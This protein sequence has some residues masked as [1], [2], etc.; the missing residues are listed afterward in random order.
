MTRGSST[1]FST[2]ASFDYGVRTFTLPG[3]PAGSYAVR[4]AATDL[5]GNFNRITATLTVGG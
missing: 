1:V 4:L 2:S 3:L 5:A